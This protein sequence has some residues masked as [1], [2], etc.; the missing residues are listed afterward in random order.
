MEKERTK[1]DYMENLSLQQRKCIEKSGRKKI[2]LDSRGGR[3]CIYA[4]KD[5]WFIAAPHF[6]CL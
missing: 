6:V 2:I 4:Q 5:G 3:E 1:T